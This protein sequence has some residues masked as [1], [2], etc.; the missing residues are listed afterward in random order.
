MKH[1]SC[2]SSHSR[3]LICVLKS[4]K[5]R[6]GEK[7]RIFPSTSDQFAI[8]SYFRCRIK[9]IDDTDSVLARSS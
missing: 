4:E 3:V 2:S 8:R 6:D 7:K 5:E 9:R 1:P